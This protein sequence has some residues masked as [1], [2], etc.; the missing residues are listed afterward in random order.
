MILCLLSFSRIELI[1]L[2]RILCINL[3]FWHYVGRL[4]AINIVMI[5]VAPELSERE[6]FPI[7]MGQISSTKNLCSQESMCQILKKQSMMHNRVT[8]LFE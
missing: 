1:P 5:G 7:T 4:E 2:K 6:R 3:P 8:R